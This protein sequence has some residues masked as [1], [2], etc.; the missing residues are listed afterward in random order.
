MENTNPLPPPTSPH[1]YLD[2][3]TNTFSCYFNLNDPSNP[4][5]LDH[6]DN[7]ALTLV[8]DPLTSDNLKTWSRAMRRVLRTKNKL[9][10]ITG[11]I[12]KLTAPSDPLL[13]LWE[14]CNDMLVSWLQNS[15]SSSIQSSVIFVD[16][17]TEI[18]M[19]LQDR[20]SQQNGPR[21]Y[22]L[23]KALYGLLQD[24]DTVSIYYG[25]LKTLWD[26]LLVYDPLPICNYGSMKNLLDQ[27]DCILQFLMG[28]HDSYS[29][30]RDQIMLL[31]PLPPITKKSLS[32]PTA[33]YLVILLK[34]AISCTVTPPG[35][36][37]HSKPH[38]SNA[39]ANQVALFFDSTSDNSGDENVYLTKLQYQ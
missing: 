35:H 13:K 26:E 29:Q 16:N 20:F 24:H 38:H 8:Y 9:G 19:D 36:K 7:P 28:L 25:K 23:K 33:T 17:A 14:C 3:P 2:K 15:I 4:F 27:G 6:G 5:R 32:A 37:F 12:L 31:D 10:F 22:Q 30:A 21:I 18:W 1:S 11:L 39:I 34:S